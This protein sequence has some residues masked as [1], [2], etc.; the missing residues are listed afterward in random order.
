MQQNFYGVG[1]KRGKGEV[2]LAKKPVPE[3]LSV[4]ELYNILLEYRKKWVRVL[5]ALLYLSGARISEALEV[6]GKDMKFLENEGVPSV[7]FRLNTRKNR[8]VKVRASYA[9]GDKPEKRWMI[10]WLRDFVR[11]LPPDDRIFTEPLSDVVRPHDKVRV[12]RREIASSE[13]IVRA[14]LPSGKVIDNY[15]M[16]IYPH[17]FRHCCITHWNEY[18]HLSMWDKVRMAGWT[19]S[20]PLQVYDHTPSEA[21]LEKM[22]K[23]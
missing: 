18:P 22:M 15:K 17:Y 6:R 12:A 16:R 10:T 8:K 9:V 4:P 7:S 11:E 2:K 23:G 3:V 1:V 5:G 14:T 19:D 21:F 20:R 13:V